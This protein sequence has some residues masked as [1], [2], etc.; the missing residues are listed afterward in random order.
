MVR[1]YK[2]NCCDRLYVGDDTFNRTCPDCGNLGFEEAQRVRYYR[3][4]NC[5]RMYVGDDLDHRSCP[6]CGNYGYEVRG[7]L[8][9][10]YSLE[11]A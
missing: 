10:T 6:D 5:N 1:F 4:A 9:Q 3:C 8:R 11:Y 7:P 2:C